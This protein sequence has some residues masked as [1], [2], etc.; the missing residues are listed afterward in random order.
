M[1]HGK[2]NKKLGKTSTHRK[3]M[4]S[5]MAVSLLRHERIQ[6]TLPKA[7]ALRPF[8]ERLITKARNVSKTTSELAVFRYLMSILKDVEIVQKLLKDVGPRFAKRA[9]GYTRIYKYGFRYGDMAP[10]A[11]MELVDRKK[12]AVAKSSK[13]GSQ[14]T[15]GSAKSTVS[16]KETA[17]RHAHH[18]DTKIR[19]DSGRRGISSVAGGK[20]PALRRTSGNASK[21]PGS[22]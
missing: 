14:K 12:D 2:A 20:A 13:E 6:T 18:A 5:N 17:A 21:G 7:K 22:A 11:L 16:H 9:G 10:V 1:R 8:V 4:F 19:K 15:E 3:A